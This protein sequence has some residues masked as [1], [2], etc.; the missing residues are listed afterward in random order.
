MQIFQEHMK[1]G[2]INY[3]QH[4][5]ISKK[6]TIWY[7]LCNI[8]QKGIAFIVIPIYVRVLSTTEYG[9]YMTFQAWRDILIIIATLN[10]YCGV[11]TKAMV[12]YVNDRDRY[13]SVMQGLST[14]ITGV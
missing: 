8:L 1:I 10:I 12:D 9:N 14:T 13:T 11:Y 2:L 6:A 5:S 4:M 3:Y 7:S